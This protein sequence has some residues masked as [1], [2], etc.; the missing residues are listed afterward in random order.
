VDRTALRQSRFLEI[1]PS[2]YLLSVVTGWAAF[3]PW[4]RIGPVPGEH[5][6]GELFRMRL[7]W[8]QPE[9]VTQLASQKPAKLVRLIPP[10]DSIQESEQAVV[11]I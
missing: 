10:F 3:S 7:V 6:L 5:P 9:V 4:K 11:F 2:A 1:A 8:I